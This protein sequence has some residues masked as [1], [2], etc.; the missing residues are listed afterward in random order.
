M[1]HSKKIDRG[2][3]YNNIHVITLLEPTYVLYMSQI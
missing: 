3:L 2:Q 1:E